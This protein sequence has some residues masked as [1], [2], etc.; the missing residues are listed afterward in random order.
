M[1]SPTSEQ[2][3]D[4]KE[5]SLNEAHAKASKW[6]EETIS[7]SSILNVVEDKLQPVITKSAD[8]FLEANQ[9]NIATYASN[10]EVLIKDLKNYYSFKDY[11][12]Y[13]TYAIDAALAVV[14]IATIVST[15]LSGGATAP[16][17]AVGYASRK[18]ISY[19]AKQFVKR[20]GIN[21][22][23]RVSSRIILKKITK[24]GLKQVGVNLS[25]HFLRSA[26]YNSLFIVAANAIEKTLTDIGL[27]AT[28]N[29]LKDKGSQLGI[30]PSLLEQ[31][32]KT[33]DDN[34]FRRVLKNTRTGI[35][36]DLQEL[37]TTENGFRKLALGA[38]FSK[39]WKTKEIAQAIER[40]DLE[41]KLKQLSKDP[42][43]KQPL[44]K[45]R[46]Q[47][48]QVTKQKLAESVK[49]S[50]IPVRLQP[51]YQSHLEELTA[52]VPTQEVS[53]IIEP[54]IEL[55][56]L[57]TDQIVDELYEV[58]ALEFVIK[59]EQKL[60]SKQ[61]TQLLGEALDTKNISLESLKRSTKQTKLTDIVYTLLKY[62]TIYIKQLLKKLSLGSQDDK[63]LDALKN[64]MMKYAGTDIYKMNLAKQYF[65]VGR[66]V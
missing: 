58:A 39:L 42:K 57:T 66:N 59:N 60:T 49:K 26:I 47:D 25:K 27:A 37:F 62:K 43:Y 24:E 18:A 32:L 4:K 11:L 13:V 44:N 29:L 6:V 53:R 48:Q 28:K 51:S 16:A 46:L 2:L 7:N 21:L 36:Q 55:A 35:S 14:G 54:K 63:M 12:K 17:A 20:Q 19:G 22:L 31:L 23:A 52:Q 15:F 30:P 41:N 8:E 9:D 10:P 5:T 1:D 61:I 34:A 64:D 45:I 65:G 56:N 38:A 50:K 33:E 40:E 3:P